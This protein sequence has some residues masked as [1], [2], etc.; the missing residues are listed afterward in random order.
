MAVGFGR[1]V[2]GRKG[3][4]VDVVR[5]GVWCVSDDI[6][7]PRNRAGDNS[8]RSKTAQ[9]TIYLVPETVQ[10]TTKKFFWRRYDYTQR[11]EVI[12]VDDVRTDCRHEKHKQTRKVP[13]RVG[14]KTMAG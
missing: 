13:R 6:F 1:E 4:G 2:Y 9:A 7:R 10:L 5:E 3:V 14:D 8:V 12:E 11:S